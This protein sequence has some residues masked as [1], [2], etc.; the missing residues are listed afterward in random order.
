MTAVELEALTTE[1]EPERRPLPVESPG[2]RHTVRLRCL[3]GAR[4][5][6]LVFWEDD[7]VRLRVELPAQPEEEVTVHVEQTAEGS[8]HVTSTGRRVITLPPDTRY[9]PPSVLRPAGAG[10]PLDLA[11]I[12]DGTTRTLTPGTDKEPPRPVPLL[13]QQ[14]AWKAHVERLAGLVDGLV[15]RHGELRLALLAFGDRPVLGVGAEDLEP[16]YELYPKSAMDRQLRRWEPQELKDSLLALPPS[17]GGDFVDALAEALQAAAELTW[18]DD[19]R[20]LVLVEGD[21]PGH[22]ILQPALHG[23]DAGGRSAEVDTCAR[24]LHG[25]GVEIVTVYHDDLQADKTYG[26]DFQGELLEHARRQYERLST[27]SDTAFTSTDF[28]VE[29]ALSRI[30]APPDL[31]GHGASQPLWI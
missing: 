21:S 13:A 10:A 25:L 20:R 26:L 14:K 2:G 28:D 17:S 27:R 30:C 24:R 18:R 8:L 19:A 7:E 5:L 23:A 22:S 12:V 3:P 16:A 4:G 15:E 29:A 6:H 9:A 11:L 1:G 31:L